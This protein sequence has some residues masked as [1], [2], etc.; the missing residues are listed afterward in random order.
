MQIC[1]I[2]LLSSMIMFKLHRCRKLNRAKV[3]KEVGGSTK[4][5]SG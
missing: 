3:V 5:V 1:S 2:R 4:H